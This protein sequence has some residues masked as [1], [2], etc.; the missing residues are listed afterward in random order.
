MENTENAKLTPRE[1]ETILLL[2]KAFS[3]KMVADAMKISIG[4]VCTNIRS[5][6]IK[7]GL[8]SNSELFVWFGCH[9]LNDF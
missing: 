1:K 5:I 2:L 9:N 3:Y 4:T 6:H 7:L 8:H